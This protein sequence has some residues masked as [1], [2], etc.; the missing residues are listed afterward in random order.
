MGVFVRV[1]LGRLGAGRVSQRG[2]FP[3]DR[4]SKILMSNLM[5]PQNEPQDN[6]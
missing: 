6:S 5:P 4:G 1:W 3:N 2:A